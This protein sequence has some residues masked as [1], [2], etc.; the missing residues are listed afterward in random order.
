[1]ATSINWWIVLSPLFRTWQLC[2]V[3]AGN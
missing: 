2:F 1:M 3:S